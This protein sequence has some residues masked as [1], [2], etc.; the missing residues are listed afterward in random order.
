MQ[1]D[2]HQPVHA[3]VEGRIDVEVKEDHAARLAQF[4]ILLVQRRDSHPQ[5][6]EQGFQPPEIGPAV[7]ACKFRGK[8]LEGQGEDEG[9][10]GPAAFAHGFAIPGKIEFVKINEELP[11][12]RRQG[13]AD[14]DRAEEIAVLGVFGEKG[15]DA[16]PEVVEAPLAPVALLDE[17]ASQLQAVLKKIGLFRVEMEEARRIEAVL[18]LFGQYL[19]GIDKPVGAGDFQIL[20]IPENEMPVVPVEAVEIPP[21]AGPFADRPED[22]FA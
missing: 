10:A 17:T 19:A 5:V 21:V 11:G 9:V 13:A 2:D 3:V 16:V 7:T 6:A 1:I 22:L 12:Q 14:T 15:A 18:A 20:V 4:G 8:R